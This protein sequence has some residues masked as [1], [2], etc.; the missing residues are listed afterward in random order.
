VLV[1]VTTV[2]K[3]VILFRVGKFH[4][5]DIFVHFDALSNPESDDNVH[6]SNLAASKHQ[7]HEEYV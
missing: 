4:V 7:R 5:L 6:L 1:C 2:L 3:S